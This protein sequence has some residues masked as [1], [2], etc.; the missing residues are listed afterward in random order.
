VYECQNTPPLAR[1]AA[2]PQLEATLRLTS[3]TAV[4][5]LGQNLT[6][7]YQQGGA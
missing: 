3:Q 5:A 4:Y 1:T 6:E 2:T 7:I